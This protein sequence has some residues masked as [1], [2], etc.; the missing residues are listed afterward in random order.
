MERLP[1]ARTLPLEIQSERE[2]GCGKIA[3]GVTVRYP[4]LHAKDLFKLV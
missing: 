4:P 2:S 3:L 1:A